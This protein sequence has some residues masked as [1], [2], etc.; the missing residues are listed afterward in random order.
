MGIL[1]PRDTEWKP[2]TIGA[3]GYL[4]GIDIAKDGTM[5]ARADTYGAFIWNGTAW[6]QI[7]TALSMPDF[8]SGNAGVYEIRIAPSNSNILYMQF[9]AGIYKSVDQGATWVK[10]AFRGSTF[11]PNGQG[12]MDGQKMAIDPTNPNVVFAGTQKD[13]L[14][15][16]RDGGSNW[17]KVAAVPQ[18]SNTG[19]PS[20]TGI[21]IQGS[22][23]YVGTAGAGV[24][25]SNDLGYTWNAIGGPADISHATIAPDGTYY[26]TGNTDTALWK[27]AGGTWTK[28]IASGVHAVALDPF[29][30]LHLVVADTGGNLI[31]SKT[32]GTTWSDWNWG[33]QLESS[34]DIPWLENSGLYMS[35]GGLVFDP[36]VAG[37]L[38][39]SAGVGVWK[40]DLPSN[41]LW[42]TPVV[43]NSQSRGIE[44]LVAND[45]I[46]PRG[47]DPLFA[48]WDRAFVSM[49]DVDKYAA[50]YSGG[51]FSMGWSV[52]YASSDPRFMVGIS[53]Y[54]GTENSGY[55]TD[56]GKT[57]TKFA[58]LPSWA[59]YTVGG[60]I[61][62]STS[63]NFIWVATG[64]QA[65]AYTLDGGVTWSNVV[66]PGVTD[67]SLVHNAFYLSRTSITADREAPNTFYLYDPATGLY[68]SSDGGANWTKVFTGEV[69]DWSVWNAKIEAVPG[70]AGELFF[71][72]GALG[73]NTMD[74][75]FTAF[76]H[77][78]DGGVTWTSVAGVGAATFGFGAPAQAGGPATIYIVGEVNGVDGIFYSKDDTQTWVKIGERPMNSLDT[79]KT[80]SGDMDKFGLVYVG[81]SGSGYAYLDFS[82]AATA[83]AP[84]PTPTPSPAPVSPAPTQLATI[85]SAL[86]DVG[87]SSTVANGAVTND[88]TPTLSGTLSAVLGTGQK[89][90]VFRDGQ[91][92]GQVSP[93]STSWSFTDP[94]ASDGQH[95]YV[96]RVVDAAGNSGTASSAFSLKVDTVAPTQAVSVTG[97]GSSANST[98]TASLASTTS[99][100]GTMVSG[101]VAGSL[102]TDEAL[103]VFRDGVRL[104]TAAVSNGSWSFNDGATSG[105]VKYTAQIE[106][107]AGNK[108]QMS[109]AFAATLGINEIGGTN[110]S[111]VLIGTGGIDHITGVGSGK[112]LGKGT[113]DTLT[114]GAGNDVF[115]LGDGRGRFYDDGSNRSSGSAD[116]VRI[117]DFSAGDKLQL[118]G[119]ASDYLQGWINNL[120]GA[121][122]TGIYHDTNGNGI[123]DARDELVAL[124][125]NHGPLDASSFIYV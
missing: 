90:S 115:V 12:R 86:D 110:R 74:P 36:N 65:P 105:S 92:I 125:Q 88:G 112:G 14:W 64:N 113:I 119:E 70:R 43:W 98:M 52:D 60:S 114:G 108:G 47:V 89:L 124:V 33:K 120:Q 39:Q 63:T 56:G 69:S 54:W 44:Q 9:D 20:M 107:A 83:P 58:G 123:L 7:V 84:V 28:L 13:G 75:T 6:Q 46:A 1:F 79:I 41:M 37:K 77:S 49:P 66:I 103:V 17:Q 11:D 96:V 95:D 104:G 68:R 57:W 101:T 22:T 34:A 23:I 72:S 42:D 27:F 24:F 87:G 97:A 18:G 53:D 32:G 55:S 19:D 45:I 4:T 94:G 121:P 73:S 5:I 31:E 48:S 106:D 51:A 21:T 71:T 117:T 35:T 82:G 122:G 50:N 91:L 116:Y 76:K 102:G 29:N 16:T 15:V 62:A 26:A 2:V 78:T 30:P 109:N 61:A 111:D 8:A 80:I 93:T 100:G 38:W 59:N 118:K 81:F 3:G 99:S 10:T 85:A 25:Q 40:T 67:W